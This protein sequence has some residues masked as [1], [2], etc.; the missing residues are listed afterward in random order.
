MAYEYEHEHRNMKAGVYSGLATNESVEEIKEVYRKA[1][2][3]DEVKQYA[4]SKNK[5]FED[6]KDTARSNKEF[7]YFNTLQ[8]ANR[9]II[10]KCKQLEDNQN[11]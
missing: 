8:I 7:N 9:A 5:D 3:F 6:R 11:D 2:A 1:K 10:N 4:L